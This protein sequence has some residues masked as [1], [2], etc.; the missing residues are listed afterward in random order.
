METNLL[1]C[2]FNL[3]GINF[4]SDANGG[5]FLLHACVSVN[6]C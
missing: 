2:E 4:G 3:V 1:F 5:H 6:L